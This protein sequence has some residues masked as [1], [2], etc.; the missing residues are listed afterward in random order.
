MSIDILPD[1]ALLEIFS[2]YLV[3]KSKHIEPWI[4]L[5]HVCRRWRS[6]IFA[7]PRRL[8]VR[9]F[10][11]P[12]RP[13]KGMLSIWPNLPIQILVIRYQSSRWQGESNV[14]AALEHADRICRIELDGPCFQLEQILPAMQKPL[15]AL[16]SLAIGCSDYDYQQAMPLIPE[17]FLGGSAQHLRSCNLLAVEFPGIWR[18]LLTANHLVTL[19]LWNIPDSMHTSPEEMTTCLS[20]MPH[21]ESLSIA[22]QPPQSLHNRPDQP[23]SPLSPLT[24][25]VLPSLTKFQ[26]QLMSECIEDFVSR[27]D[28]P[29]LDK[30]DITFFDQ[31]VFDTP[32]LHDFLTRIENSEAHSRGNVAFGPSCIKFG[33]ELGPLSFE[34]AILCRG[35][36]RQVS[37]MAQLCS[38]SLYLPSALERLDIR[39]SHLVPLW[40]RQDDVEDSDPQLLDLFRP[41]TGLKDLRLSGGI[42]QHYALALREL[43]RERLTEV[44]PELQNLFIERLE[45]SG[46]IQEAIGQFAAERQLSGLPV[47]IHSWDGLS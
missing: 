34:L 32:R 27:I 11:T 2:F 38:S 17:A 22:F 45:P 1:E 36:G 41:F 35:I 8:D 25:V 43:A 47:M 15:P 6:I 4:P 31:P 46:P 23:N 13:V 40:Y 9:V 5:V 19:G 20:T 37:S 26:F 14:V 7:S 28:V 10:Y 21:L 24:R 30:F 29:L 33:L 44:L 42:V 18:L 3:E 39:G 16:A 12:N